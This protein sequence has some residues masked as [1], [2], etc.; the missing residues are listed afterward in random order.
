MFETS[1]RVFSS[2]EHWTT[3]YGHYDKVL[4]VISRKHIHSINI[5]LTFEHFE[6]FWIHSNFRLKKSK[7]RQSGL[8]R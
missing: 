3:E 1:Y 5:Q 8:K 7:T 6:H 2:P 4:N